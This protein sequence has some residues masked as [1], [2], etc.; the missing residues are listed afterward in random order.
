MPVVQEFVPKTIIAL[1]APSAGGKKTTL[2]Y[3]LRYVSEAKLMVSYTD[4]PQGPGEKDRVDYYFVTAAKFD[5]ILATRTILTYGTH[6]GHRY[7]DVMPEGQYEIV[8]IEVK[9]ETAID[10]R[11]RYPRQTIIVW[12]DPPGWTE[13]MKIMFLLGRLKGR[14]RDSRNSMYR[15]LDCA[16]YEMKAGPKAANVCYTNRWSHL[17]AWRMAL[18]VRRRQL[19]H[20]IIKRVLPRWIWMWWL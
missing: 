6:D 17:T 14:N 3:F 8:T 12:L 19:I 13:T 20:C 10:V 4:R 5:E 2:G 7:C 11:R 1:A 9:I 18:L 16:R 15:R